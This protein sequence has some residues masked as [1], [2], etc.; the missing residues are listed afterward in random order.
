ME[1][2]VES[3]DPNVTSETLAQTWFNCLDGAIKGTTTRDQEAAEVEE[4]PI[5][6]KGADP[7]LADKKD[8]NEEEFDFGMMDEEGM[9]F[10]D[11]V[12]GFGEGFSEEAPAEPAKDKDEEEESFGF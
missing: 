6:R 5:V 11:E 4:A 1:L 9:G 12:T 3:T 7:N 10:G 2:I 8:E